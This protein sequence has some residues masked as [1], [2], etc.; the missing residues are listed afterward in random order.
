[1]VTPIIWEQGV[2]TVNQ[3]SNEFEVLLKLT[4]QQCCQSLEIP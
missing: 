4:T 1:M 3:D 2:E